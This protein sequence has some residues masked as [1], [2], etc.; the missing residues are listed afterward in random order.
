VVLASSEDL[1]DRAISDEV[2]RTA[3]NISRELGA[4]AWPPRGT[5][6]R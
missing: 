5:R 2:R 4:I 6:D 1:E 3:V